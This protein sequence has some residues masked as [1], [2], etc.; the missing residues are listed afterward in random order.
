[1]FANVNIATLSCSKILEEFETKVLCLNGQQ[2][3]S[4]NADRS[5]TTATMTSVS[6]FSYSI[7]L[8]TMQT[9]VLRNLNWLDGI[10]VVIWCSA[11]RKSL[12]FDLA[13]CVVVLGHHA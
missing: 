6:P 2:V 8:P 3:A 11:K 1:M 13:K 9:E 12:G 7:T 10:Y 4:E 5:Y